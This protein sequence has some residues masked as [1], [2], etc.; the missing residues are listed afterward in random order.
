M[1]ESVKMKTSALPKSWATDSNV[2]D[3]Q[4]SLSR[5]DVGEVINTGTPHINLMTVHNEE[6]LPQGDRW[7]NGWGQF[8]SRWRLEEFPRQNLSS[9]D[10]LDGSACHTARCKSRIPISLSTPRPR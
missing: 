8:G 10:E 5:L 2:P 7:N 4:Q 9:L 1:R 6:S 3:L